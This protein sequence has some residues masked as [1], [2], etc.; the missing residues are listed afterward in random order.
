MKSIP[1]IPGHMASD[2]RHWQDDPPSRFEWSVIEMVV[3]RKGPP[4]EYA[5]PS[6]ICLHLAR[7]AHQLRFMHGVY[8]RPVLGYP[9]DPKVD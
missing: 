2:W 8:W 9:A 1:T 5:D 7:Y 3:S 4:G 6:T